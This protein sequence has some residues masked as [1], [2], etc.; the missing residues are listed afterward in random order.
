M[1]RKKVTF[2]I[3]GG[4]IRL[5]KISPQEK[6]ELESFLQDC[7][8]EVYILKE[9]L[10]LRERIDREFAS[11]WV[12]KYEYN[13]DIAKTNHLIDQFPT[14]PKYLYVK[15]NTGTVTAR[16]DSQN[17]P[18]WSLTTKDHFRMPFTSLY[19]SWAAQSGKEIVI[20]LSNREILRSTLA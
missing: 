7:P 11:Q 12:H 3:E 16:F 17:E 6:E 1:I 14:P 13:L 15:S 9:L 18:S 4:E 19:L 10:S 2:E 8:I 5:Y 20:Y